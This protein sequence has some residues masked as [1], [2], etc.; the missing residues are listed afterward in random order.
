MQIGVL[1]DSLNFRGGAEKVCL[2]T[3]SAVQE[4]GHSVV[5]GTI[6]RTDWASV[7]SFLGREVRPS[8]E[9]HLW[10][11]N[12]AVFRVYTSTLLPIV[13]SRL[14]RICG[15]CVFT[16]L[17]VFPLSVD[18]GYLHFLPLCAI[19]RHGAE[20][21]YSDRRYIYSFLGQKAQNRALKGL[22]V[23][24]LIANSSFSRRMIRDNMGY[25]PVVIHPPVDVR[26]F[27]P[28]GENTRKK[29]IVAVA[30]LSPEKNL[31]LVLSVAE[32]TPEADVVI[33]GSLAG[34]S[35]RQYLNELRKAVSSR[36]ITNVSIL[37]NVPW[38]S[39]VRILHSSSVFLNATKGETFGIAVVEA[40]AAGVVPVVHRSGGQW[41]DILAKSDG[42]HGFSFA[43]AKEAVEKA[44]AVLSD[45]R[46]L[47][48]IQRRNEAWVENFSSKR[49]R[50]K[51]GAIVGQTILS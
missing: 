7:D 28:N 40:M 23:K 47:H 5:L 14:R 13:L 4:L 42:L 19:P 41:E 25:D 11:V 9:V 3:I 29:R 24:R 36:K 44:R 1:H 27:A 32:K 18:V 26:R 6:D 21:P 16:N 12:S 49:F 10:G 51:M 2:E 22:R 50:E 33:I 17:D 30:R 38:Q 31:G 43:D 46:M 15:V 45:E 39:A 35:S 37:V 48:T 8:K 34:A 20:K